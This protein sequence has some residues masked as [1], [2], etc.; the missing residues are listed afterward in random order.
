MSIDQDPDS[1]LPPRADATPSDPPLTF[2]RPKKIIVTTD[3]GPLHKHITGCGEAFIQLVSLVAILLG[4]LFYL[5]FLTTT[6]AIVSGI[7]T[8]VGLLVIIAVTLSR[9]R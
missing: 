7:W 9:R 3:E 6:P 8:I 1:L 4:V 5:I 2:R